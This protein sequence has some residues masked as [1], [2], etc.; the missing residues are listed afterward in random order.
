MQF[1][2]PL[3]TVWFIRA[4]PTT[5]A[6]QEGSAVAIRLQRMAVQPDGSRA[7]DA[8]TSRTYLVTCAHVLRESQGRRIDGEIGGQSSSR[9]IPDEGI[10]AW[11]PGVG[12]NAEQAKS[13]RVC[14]EFKFTGGDETGETDKKSLIKDWVVLEIVDDDAAQEPGIHEHEWMNDNSATV[15]KFGLS[16]RFCVIGYPGGAES[17]KKGISHPTKSSL[18][19][20]REVSQGLLVLNGDE[21]RPGMSGGGVFAFP[22]LLGLPLP[23]KRPL[24]AGIHRGRDNNTLQLSALSSELIRSHIDSDSVPFEIVRSKRRLAKRAMAP[25]LGSLLVVAFT[26]VFWWYLQR[27]T[28]L[29]LTVYRGDLINGN[30][31]LKPLSGVQVGI[32]PSDCKLKWISEAATDSNGRGIVRFVADSGRK[33]INGSFFITD[34]PGIER[35]I[36]TTTPVFSL[37]DGTLDPRGKGLKLEHGDNLELVVV[38]EALYVDYMAAFAYESIRNSTQYRTAS[39]SKDKLD[40]FQVVANEIDNLEMEDNKLKNKLTESVATR[41]FS[42]LPEM[43]KGAVI[44]KELQ[45]IKRVSES[46]AIDDPELETRLQ[47][48]FAKVLLGARPNV[49]TIKEDQDW[50]GYKATLDQILGKKAFGGEGFSEDLLKKSNDQANSVCYVKSFASNSGQLRTSGTGFVIGKQFVLTHSDVVY[51]ESQHEE[52]QIGFGEDLDDESDKTRMTVAEVIRFEESELVLLRVPN[53]RRSALMISNRGKLNETNSGEMY[54]IGYCVPSDRWPQFMQDV[55]PFS[56]RGEKRIAF[57]MF[58][59]GQNVGGRF[60]DPE[61]HSALTSPGTIGSPVIDAESGLVVGIH[62][63]GDWTDDGTKENYFVPSWKIFENAEFKMML[64]HFNVMN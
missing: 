24:L 32:V 52:V 54:V 62:E 28:E 18:L 15:P 1:W 41:V 23:W 55:L 19:A 21:T 13:V 7:G 59:L 45:L 3:N 27:P 25:L 53:L 30:T 6:P 35:P 14:K 29:Y 42:D 10:R 36:V 49:P 2:Y 43:Q 37:G 50:S 8:S 9:F 46:L 12:L 20:L 51:K 58:S 56:S 40:K 44:E 34:A 39:A 64:D 63:G 11:P 38:P 33:I 16:N 47:T 17:L 60:E 4:T 61:F 48:R 22:T 31:S 57:G 5:G 26:A